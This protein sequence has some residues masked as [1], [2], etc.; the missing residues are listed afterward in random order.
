[1]VPVLAEL[2]GWNAVDSAVGTRRWEIVV[3]GGTVT[4]PAVHIHEGLLH[5]D[6]LHEVWAAAAG[7]HQGHAR[8]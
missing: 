6:L 2:H 8:R 5:L 1:M 3:H 7:I 4:A